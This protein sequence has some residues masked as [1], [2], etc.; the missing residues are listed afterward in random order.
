MAHPPV[1]ESTTELDIRCMVVVEDF[2]R[3]PMFSRSGIWIGERC[4]FKQQVVL[5]YEHDPEQLYVGWAIN[6]STVF[7]PGLSAGSR[8]E[9]DPVPGAAGLAMLWPSRATATRSP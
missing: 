8:P 4:E 1:V 3:H 9:G 5:S 6:G 2:T 7:D